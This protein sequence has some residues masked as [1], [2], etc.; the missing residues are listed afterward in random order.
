MR[1]AAAYWAQARQQGRPTADLRELDC[2]VF[3][4]AQARSA[5]DSDDDFIVATTNIRHRSLFVPAA[6]WWTIS[7]DPA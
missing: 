5:Y 4:A 7:P 1:L 6:E 2:D 3:I